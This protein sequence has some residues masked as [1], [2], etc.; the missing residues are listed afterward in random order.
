MVGGYEQ[1]LQH[2]SDGDNVVVFGVL[3]SEVVGDTG[4]VR[5]EAGDF[6]GVRGD[7]A[8]AARRI[9]RDMV[10]KVLRHQAALHTG[11]YAYGAALRLADA[12]GLLQDLQLAAG[13][14]DARESEDGPVRFNGDSFLSIVSCTGLPA[15]ESQRSGRSEP[16]LPDQLYNLY[17]SDGNSIQKG[18]VRKEG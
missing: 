10:L 1:N 14:S 17:G 4:Q 15:G 7:S 2:V 18:V 3:P 8:D 9:H 12:R 13:I 6:Q 16:G 11:V 5:A